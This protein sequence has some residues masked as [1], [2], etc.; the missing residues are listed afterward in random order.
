MDE[1]ELVRVY[2]E[3]LEPSFPASELLTEQVFVEWCLA[4]RLDVVCEYADGV[5]AAV[6]VAAPYE[7]AGLVLLVW[8]AARPGVR[9][10]GHGGRV[11]TRALELWQQRYEPELVVGEAELPE[12]VEASEEHGDPA[13]RLRFYDRHGAR[14]LVMTHAQ[15]PYR[16]GAPELE[17]ELF[18]LRHRGNRP[19]EQVPSAPV[20]GFEQRY[21]QR[22][23]EALARVLASIPRDEVA[24]RPLA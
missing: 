3:I 15:P 12:Q 16:P 24:T 4:G 17:L 11:L 18:V 23:P 6:A 21:L 14:G 10:G 1:A 7:Q 8:L 2:R 5:L 19:G 20:V 13:A 9:G 22:A